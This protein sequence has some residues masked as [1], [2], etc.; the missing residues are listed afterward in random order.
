MQKW[1]SISICFHMLFFESLHSLWKLHPRDNHMFVVDLLA[2]F[3]WQHNMIRLFMLGLWASDWLEA[4]KVYMY[5]IK[6]AYIC[7]TWAITDAEKRWRRWMSKWID[8]LINELINEWLH[9][10]SSQLKSVH[11]MQTSVHFRQTLNSTF[12]HFKFVE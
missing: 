2:R 10:L 11:I 8:E 4:G 7:S 6:L 12:D 3:Q 9:E 1:K 5:N